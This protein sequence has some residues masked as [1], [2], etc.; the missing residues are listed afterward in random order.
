V[1]RR[2]S[3]EKEDDLGNKEAALHEDM[4]EI[5]RKAIDASLHEILLQHWIVKGVLSDHVR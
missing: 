3:A 2:R 1:G 5:N 4:N